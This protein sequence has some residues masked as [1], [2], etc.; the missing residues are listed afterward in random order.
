VP[1]EEKADVPFSVQFAQ[2][3]ANA[4]HDR[5]SEAGAWYQT[6]V[7]VL[8]RLGWVGEA[9]A[10][11]VHT[12]AGSRPSGRPSSVTARLECIS[13]PQTV[14]SDSSMR[15]FERSDAPLSYSP[16]AG[17]PEECPRTEVV[18]PIALLCSD[19]ASCVCGTVLDINGGIYMN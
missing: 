9:F 10:L 8:E 3:A 12:A 11:T 6:L 5:F 15:S 13:S 17:T 16:N 4:R 2:R 7:V 1:A 14:C 18:W 19:A